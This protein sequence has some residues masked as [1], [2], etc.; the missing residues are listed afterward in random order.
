[1]P[2]LSPVCPCGPYFL[3]LSPSIYEAFLYFWYKMLR[4]IQAHLVLTCFPPL[5][6]LFIQGGQVSSSGVW[7]LGAKIWPLDVLVVLGVS[8]VLGPLDGQGYRI[9]LC[10]HTHA[11]TCICNNFCIHLGVYILPNPA[12]HL[13]FSILHLCQDFEVPFQVVRNL[14]PISLHMYL[15]TTI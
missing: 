8:L 10:V 9:Y 2:R 12:Q 15:F 1:M 5:K 13:I 3:S 6:H 14:A 7:Y 4:Y 11:H